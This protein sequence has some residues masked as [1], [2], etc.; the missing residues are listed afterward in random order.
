MFVCAWPSTRHTCTLHIVVSFTDCTHLMVCDPQPFHSCQ[1]KRAARWTQKHGK[2]VFRLDAR[3][4]CLVLLIVHSETEGV[5][6]HAFRDVRSKLQTLYDV[7]QRKGPT[8]ANPFW[9]I[10]VLAR[11][12]V[13][14]I[15]F[16]P[17]HFWPIHMD[18]G[19]CVMVGPQG[20][21]LNPEKNRATKGGDPKDGATTA[22]EPKRAHFRALALQTPPKFHEKTPRERQRER[23]WGG[24][25][26]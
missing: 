15:H 20:W 4:V 14:Q 19:V 17:F 10:L 23:K 21:S 9:A 18:L 3:G 26:K 8:L 11:L 22:R 24:R 25:G 12:F 6:P 7:F 5:P 16:W 13:G 1:A 2:T